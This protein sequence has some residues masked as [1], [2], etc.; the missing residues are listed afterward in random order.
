MSILTENEE[1]WTKHEVLIYHM[2]TMAKGTCHRTS[3]VA[4]SLRV[5]KKKL[6]SAQEC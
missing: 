2:D 1:R 6:T 5:I 3:N 4:A